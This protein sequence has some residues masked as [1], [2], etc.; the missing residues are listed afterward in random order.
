MPLQRESMLKIW[1]RDLIVWSHYKGSS[2]V[3]NL[4]EPLLYLFALVPCLVPCLYLGE[5]LTK[6]NGVNFR[7]TT[8]EKS[9]FSLGRA[10]VDLMKVRPYEQEAARAKRHFNDGVFTPASTRV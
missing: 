10:F 5:N 6:K 3:A 4:G 8:V 1:Y 2:L 9:E 7:V